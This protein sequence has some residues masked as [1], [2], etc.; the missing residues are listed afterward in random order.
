MRA[1]LR[2]Q[3]RANRRLRGLLAAAAVALVV[4]LVAGGLALA[5]RSRADDQAR[6]ADAR[7]LAV[8]VRD[9]TATRPDL[10]MLLAVEPFLESCAFFFSA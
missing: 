3:S 1:R 4:A 8:Q 5:Q 9:L 6:L 7:R 10:L 2:V